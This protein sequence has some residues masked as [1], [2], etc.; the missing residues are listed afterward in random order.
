MRLFDMFRDDIFDILSDYQESMGA[1][2]YLPDYV[3]K[4]AGTFSTFANAAV[5]TA[6]E[7]IAY[8]ITGG[9]FIEEEEA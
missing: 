7:I 5:W 8:E 2:D 6:A 1:D 4:N 9:E 3:R